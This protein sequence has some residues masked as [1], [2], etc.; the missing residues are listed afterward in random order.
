MPTGAVE[1]YY[2]GGKKFETTNTG[3][4]VTGQIVAGG[5]NVTGSAFFHANVHLHDN[6]ILKIGTGNDLQISHDGTSSL[7]KSVGHPIAH[8]SNTRHHF[9]NADGTANVAVLVPGA[10]CE[11]YHN[12]GKRLETTDRGITVSGT[13]GNALN[14][15]GSMGASE[16][17]KISNTS[18][19]DHIQFGMQQQDSDGLHHRGFIIAR[20]GTGS[21]TGQLELLARGVGGGTNRG[22]FIDAGS[23]IK[24]SLSICPDTNNNY[25]L[26]TTALR[27]RNI[28]TN[29]LNLS[30]EGGAGNDV[31]GTTGNYT[32]QE[33]ADELYLINNKSGKKY[34]FNL[35]EVS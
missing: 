25:D 10:Q 9:L 14:L 34:K 5:L 31:D 8:Y 30:N 12:S 20:K 21:V 27:W 26:G 18:S 11:F 6:D 16:Q 24:S 22:F 19:G 7:I 2:D 13:G 32:I 1:L 35:T 23:N 29:D 33:G 28:Y 17:F 4:T 15:T 3:A